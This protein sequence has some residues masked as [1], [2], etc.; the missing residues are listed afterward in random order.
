MNRI[1]I[2]LTV[3][4]RGTMNL[5]IQSEEYNAPGIELFN[6]LWYKNTMEYAL[7][8]RIGKPELFIGREEELEYLLN[9]AAGIKNE[10]S[11][12]TALLARRKMGKTAIMQR[13]FNILFHKNDGVIPFYFEVKEI[14]TWALTFSKDF[15]FSFIY[16]YISFKSRKVEYLALENVGDF[17]ETIR[18]AKKEGLDY[19]IGFIEG[20]AHSS[21]LEDV[22]TTWLLVRDLPRKLAARRDEFILQMIDEFQFLNSKIFWDKEKTNLADNFAGGYLS[23]AESKVA[24]LLVSGSWVGWLMNLLI[25]M[26]PARFKYRPLESMPQHEAIKMIYKYSHF[27]NISITEEIAFVMA[28]LTEGSPFY[29]SSLFRSDF[30]EKNFTNMDGLL[31]TLEFETLNSRGEIKSTWMEYIETAFHRVND[32]NAKNI[33]LYM[34]KNRN[35]EVTRK[36]LMDILKLDMTDTELEKKLKALVNADVITQGQSNFRYQGVRDNIFDK[37][38]RGVYQEEIEQYEPEQITNEYI[39]QLERQKKRYLQLQGKFNYQKGYFA[40]YVIID[41]LRYNS[42]KKNELL[43]SITRN[44]PGNFEFREYK[45]VWTYQT[46]VEHSKKISVDILAR[47]VSEGNYSIIGEVKNRDTKKFSKTEAEEFMAK[48]EI[49]KE[50]EN[51]NRV[52]GFIFSRKGFTKDCEEFLQ[53]NHIAYTDDEQWLDC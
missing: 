51:L 19:L 49:I 6:S 24:P 8:E 34:C 18:V 40:E 20:V 35:R 42:V 17:E 3:Y 13:L 21:E 22:D 50:K 12:S 52:I 4:R 2:I 30:K 16:Q 46:T 23:T 36:E 11:K 39:E 26:L 41:Q 47:P 25:M 45:D 10:M 15:F 7:K 29:I 53:A 27:F 9:W 5:T 43:Q 31:G 14:D 1:Y 48:F 44:L 38:F 32:R 33:V 37:V 28:E